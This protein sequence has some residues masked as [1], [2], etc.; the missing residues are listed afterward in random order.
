M[1]ILLALAAGLKLHRAANAGSQHHDAHD[2]F[3]VDAPL[4]LGKPDF[5]GETAGQ[6][7]QFGGGARMQPELI[8]DR[9][10]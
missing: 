8:A 1:R 4:T 9:G 3:G 5:T 6:L 10:A 2:A 7:G